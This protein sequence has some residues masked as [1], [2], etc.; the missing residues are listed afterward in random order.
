[1]RQ[2]VL[3]SLG[4]NIHRIWSDDWLSDKS[5]EVELIKS[6]INN[7]VLSAPVRVK[8]EDAFEEVEEE[9][10][11]PQF[12]PIEI[13]P[14]YKVANLQQLN[15]KLEFDSYGR[16]K[17]SYQRTMIIDVMDGI[18][19]V[20]SPLSV[21]LLYKRI[22][23]NI[24]VGRMGTRITKLYNDIL[25]RKTIGKVAF[26]RGDTVSKKSIP[27]L[28]PIRISTEQ[29]R[30]FLSIPIEELA[31]ASII[32]I[33]N[34]GAISEEHL[35]KN[36]ARLFYDNTRSGKKILN[37]MKKVVRHLESNGYVERDSDNLLIKK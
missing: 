2:E 13:F 1:V 33:E 32:I 4:W 36:V 15:M 9:Q 3:E 11:I 23:A 27:K 10:G 14:K 24:G 19:D 21:D 16:L 30:P 17:R 28:A 34:M 37:K 5:G 7:L 18:L 8:T 25:S 29:D 22:N 20:E 31:N 26:K 12:D 6:K 35:S